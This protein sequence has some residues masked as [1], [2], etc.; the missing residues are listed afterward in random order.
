MLINKSESE[1][2]K[3]TQF[4]K[5]H[6]SEVYRK[7]RE[8]KLA[9]RQSGALVDE[10]ALLAALEAEHLSAAILDVTREEPLPA[11]S[12]LWDAPNV[13]LSPHSAVSPQAYVGSVLELFARNLCRY[14]AGEAP[15][16]LVAS[17]A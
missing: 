17:G 2:A 11:D 13:Y 9:A 14:A 7:M 10:A 3:L 5:D 6:V 4:W 15:E 12:P 8:E 16:N 1:A